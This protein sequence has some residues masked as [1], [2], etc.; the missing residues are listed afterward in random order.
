[1]NG[2]NGRDPL[3]L[4]VGKTE[5]EVPVNGKF[6]LSFSGVNFSGKEKA[7]LVD[8]YEECGLGGA[9]LSSQ[10]LVGPIGQMGITNSDKTKI[11]WFNL[12]I[13]TITTLKICF[14]GGEC[15]SGQNFMLTIG[16]VICGNAGSLPTR[17][18]ILV[19]SSVFEDSLTQFNKLQTAPVQ[20]G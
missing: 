4:G 5:I 2:L 3:G 13:T 18:A 14:C 17:D 6:S 10:S 11:E 9:Q 19:K 16:A 7:S 20:V 15:D 8:S 12:Q 1:M